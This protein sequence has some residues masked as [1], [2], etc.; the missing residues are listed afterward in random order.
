[1]MR[2]AIA[3][4]RPCSP[5][6]LIWLSEMC[7]QMMPAMKPMPEKRPMRDATSEMIASVFV[8]APTG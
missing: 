8:F 5:V 4:P 3:I 7:P 1:M 2:P 6:F